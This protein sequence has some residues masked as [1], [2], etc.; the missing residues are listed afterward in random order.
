M[1]D[2]QGLVVALFGAFAG[3]SAFGVAIGGFLAAGGGIQ[4][5]IY[6]W[7]AHG[8]REVEEKIARGELVAGTRRV[9]RAQRLAKLRKVWFWGITVLIG[10][11]VAASG[12]GLLASFWWLHTGA[13]WALRATMDLF[14][15]EAL[16][17]T[18]VTLV[19]VAIA[20]AGAATG[21][22]K[23][24]GPVSLGARAPAQADPGASLSQSLPGGAPRCG[25]GWSGQVSSL[26]IR[27][28]WPRRRRLPPGRPGWPPSRRIRTAGRTSRRWPSCWWSSRRCTTPSRGPS[29]ASPGC[30]SG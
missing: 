5:A 22:G 4:S 16:S 28:S 3:F 12:C 9:A 8:L 20:A 27:W 6:N 25:Q 2:N 30:W 10:L 7:Q 21:G 1:V 19:S 26:A 14:I 18:F 17:L 15:A 11:V 23:P 13:G 29:S 24:G